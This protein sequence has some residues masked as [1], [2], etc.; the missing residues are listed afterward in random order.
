MTNS[1]TSVVCFGE[2][3]LRLS[4][5]GHRLL[6]QADFLESGFGG[7]EANV[8]AA[9]AMLGHSTRMIS[10]LPTGPLGD[11]ALHALRGHGVDIRSIE[12]RDGRLGIY[13]LVSGG[14]LRPSE[15]VYD[16]EGSLFATTPPSNYDWGTLLDGAHWLHL[17]GI[18]PALGPDLALAAIEAARAARAAGIKVSFDGNYRARLWERWDS[19]PREVLSA[20]VH[21]ADIL[22]GNHRDIAL[23]LD[24]PFSGEGEHRRREA[25]DA[26]FAAFPNLA[27]IA[28]TARQVD[29]FDAHRISARIDTRERGY[30]TRE[31]EVTA[32][33]DRIGGGDAFAAGV[34]HELIRSGDEAKAANAGLA[35]A[36]LKHSLPGDAALFTQRDIDLFESGALDVQR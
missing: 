5:P 26:A 23:L 33:V 8:A 3:L 27:F 16:R 20:L 13:F 32:I 28:S 36:C 22:F 24:R 17:S 6:S 7:A 10:T 11:A 19:R 35:L 31:V 21:E 1:E 12:R 2:I 30:Q 15:I 9:L 34:L 25:A 14:S 29:Q 18:T 4:T